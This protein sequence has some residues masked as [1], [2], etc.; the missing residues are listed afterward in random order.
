MQDIVLLGAPVSASPS[1]WRSVRHVV[2]GRVINCYCTT[3]FVL[4]FVYRANQIAWHVAGVGP[5]GTREERPQSPRATPATVSHRPR[6][7]SPRVLSSLKSPLHAFDRKP[8]AASALEAE[9]AL[10][11]DDSA[12]AGSATSP[13]IDSPSPIRVEEGPAW[14]SSLPPA[15]PTIK[16]FEGIENV[17]VT[18]IVTGHL[19]YRNKLADVL[20]FVGIEQ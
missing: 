17:D 7:S 14:T 5:V 1:R 19:D 3:D 15:H 8:S 13:A 11:P 6:R 10:E 2:A 12:S 4:R 16:W 9:V 20:R 18:P